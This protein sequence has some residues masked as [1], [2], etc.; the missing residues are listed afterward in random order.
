MLLK[1]NRIK[2]KK[3]F[4][5]IF[6]NS[7]SFKNDFFIFRIAKNNLG[8]NRFGFVVGLKISKK[9]TIRNKTRRRM[10]EIIKAEAEKIKNGTDLIL[11]ALSGIEKKG[12]SEMKDIINKA[13]IKTGLI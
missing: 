1:I 8:I 6:K 3:D 7:K 4:G 13:L 10:V 11:I 12:F 5:N 9:A 2:K